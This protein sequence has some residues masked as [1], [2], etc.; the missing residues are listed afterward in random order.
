MLKVESSISGCVK[1][2]NTRNMIS[3][4]NMKIATFNGDGWLTIMLLSYILI[5]NIFSVVGGI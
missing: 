2:V 5:L 1:R 4:L 3:P